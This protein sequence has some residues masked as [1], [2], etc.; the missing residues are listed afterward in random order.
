MARKLKSPYAGPIA[1]GFTPTRWRKPDT[2]D[3]KL[4]VQFR[5]RE[6]GLG[7]QGGDWREVGGPEAKYPYTASQVVWEDRGHEWDIVAVTKWVD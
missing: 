3:M 5:G 7:F 6:G 4:F 2:G 1:P